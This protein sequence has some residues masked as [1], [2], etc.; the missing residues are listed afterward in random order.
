MSDWQS[1]QPEPDGQTNGQTNDLSN[2]TATARPPR[3]EAKYQA[4]REQGWSEPQEY[5]YAAAAAPV[6]TTPGEASA[7]QPMWGHKSRRYEWDDE[8][9]DVGP[10]VPELEKDLFHGEFQMRR[11]IRF[12]R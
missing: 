10:E 12:D 7:D 2:G 11:G 9:G 5:D 8:F 3:D 6:N 1:T 4:A